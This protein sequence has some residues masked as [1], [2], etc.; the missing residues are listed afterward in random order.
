MMLLQGSWDSQV[1]FLLRQEIYLLEHDG[2][3]TG[4]A[5]GGTL[6]KSCK[7]AESAAARYRFVYTVMA[8]VPS[9]TFDAI[10][11]TSN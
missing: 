4:A 9:R 2:F 6:C 8:Y 7:Q 10:F 3:T 1:D 5:S 11:R